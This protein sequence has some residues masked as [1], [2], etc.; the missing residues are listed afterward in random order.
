[1]TSQENHGKGTQM[2]QYLKVEART[3]EPG[4]VIIFDNRPGGTVR[5]VTLR[6]SFSV[7]L[8][9]GDGSLVITHRN[10]LFQRV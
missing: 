6:G 8:Q 9:M 10:A 7:Y 3:L 1:M 5:S 4:D 2:N